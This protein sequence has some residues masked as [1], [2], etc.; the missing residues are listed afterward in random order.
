MFGSGFTID[1][2]GGMT[3]TSPSQISNG[4]YSDGVIEGSELDI[5][6]AYHSKL[7]DADKYRY[8]VSSIGETTFGM[9]QDLS[10]MSLT[11]GVNQSYLSTK[12]LDNSR[13]NFTSF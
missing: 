5:G 8:H 1:G 7:S 11:R 6:T 12:I 3:I 13:I 10:L 2:N 4:T 9:S